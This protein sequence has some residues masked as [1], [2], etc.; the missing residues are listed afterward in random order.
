[1][2]K[3]VSPLQITEL[4]KRIRKH[5]YNLRYDAE[6]LQLFVNSIHYGTESISYLGPK[7]WGMLPHISSSPAHFFAIR[8]RRKRGPGTLQTRD[9]NL[10]K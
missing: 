10:S 6:F 5:P 3:G 7:I 4:F 8:R 9:Q 1:M 2:Y